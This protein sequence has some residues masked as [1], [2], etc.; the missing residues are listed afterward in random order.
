VIID[1]EVYLAHHGVKGMK[2]GTR[3]ERIGNRGSGPGKQ[4]LK[5]RPKAAKNSLGRSQIPRMILGG[6]IGAVGT[7]MLVSTLLS[8]HGDTYIPGSGRGHFTM[9]TPKPG[10]SGGSSATRIPLKVQNLND[11]HSLP[12]RRVLELNAG[13]PMSNVNDWYH[14]R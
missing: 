6:T 3:K 1:E 7:A 4:P 9:F 5:N 8:A 10:G 14:R 11:Y 12:A 2:W 13:T